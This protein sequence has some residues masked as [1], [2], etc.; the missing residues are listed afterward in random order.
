MISSMLV[1]KVKKPYL[2]HCKLVSRCLI[3]ELRFTP[4]IDYY[5]E[6]M[7]SALEELTLTSGLS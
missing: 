6:N 2:S 4:A 3:L 7:V 5:I 1:F